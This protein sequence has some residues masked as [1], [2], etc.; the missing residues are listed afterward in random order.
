MASS[1]RY[2]AQRLTEAQKDTIRRSGYSDG[3]SMEGAYGI[4]DTLA[5]TMVDKWGQPDPT[6]W[7]V[8]RAVAQMRARY[9]RTIKVRR[10]EER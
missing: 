1:A 9:L 3:S 7:A 10:D 2:R 8:N 5:K 6:Y 4:R